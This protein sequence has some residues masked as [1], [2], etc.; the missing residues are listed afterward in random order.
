MMVNVNVSCNLYYIKKTRRQ[1]ACYVMLCN[2]YKKVLN[3]C[4]R[5]A[6]IPTCRNTGLHH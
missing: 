1:C 3:A 5:L 2:D 4:K 6:G